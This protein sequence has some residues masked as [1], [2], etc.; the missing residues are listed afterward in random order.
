[1]SGGRRHVQPARRRRAAL[2]RLRLT[3][4]RMKSLSCSIK[5]K[6]ATLSSR[7]LSSIA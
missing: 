5:P 4:D 7:L 2:S 1:V 3:G 6:P